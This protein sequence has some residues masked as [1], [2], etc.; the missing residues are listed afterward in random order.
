MSVATHSLSMVFIRMK[1]VWHVL[2]DKVS[3]DLIVTFIANSLTLLLN[4]AV[5]YLW[6]VSDDPSVLKTAVDML[7][8]DQDRLL[9]VSYQ[10]YVRQTNT[11][12]FE[13]PKNVIVCS[14]PDPSMD[15]ESAIAEAKSLFYQCEESHVEFMPM[16]EEQEG[17]NI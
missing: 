13:L 4:E 6:T 7:S 1:R 11:S 14:D 10:Q 15:F 9:S 3:F 5:T 2:K 8:K 12:D 16:A 17:D